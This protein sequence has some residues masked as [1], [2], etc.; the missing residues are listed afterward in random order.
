MIFEVSLEKI[1]LD[2]QVSNSKIIKYIIDLSNNVNFEEVEDML[3]KNYQNTFDIKRLEDNK[4]QISIS[5]N[6]I[7]ELRIAAI[8]QKYYYFEKSGK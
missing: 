4:L 8:K 1:K 6:A 2:T 7:N 5:E 3:N